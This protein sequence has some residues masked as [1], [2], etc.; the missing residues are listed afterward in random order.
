M[1]IGSLLKVFTVTDTKMEGSFQRI[2]NI[3]CLIHRMFF[4]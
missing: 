3:S 2:V 4:P 1:K